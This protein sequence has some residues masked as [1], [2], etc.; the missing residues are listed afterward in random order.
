MVDSDP[1]R[2][3]EKR[4]RIEWS[5]CHCTAH[6]Q[7]SWASQ[8]SQSKMSLEWASE[9]LHPIAPV[10]LFSPDPGHASHSFP[11]GPYRPPFFQSMVLPL[12]LCPQ[13]L[14]TG[15]F[16]CLELCS[17]LFSL[18][19]IFS[20]TNLDLISEVLCFGKPS[21]TSLTRSNAPCYH[22]C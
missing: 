18:L 5:H 13:G 19:C 8:G 20:N 17:S 10:S 16:W 22:F 1:R 21:L 3:S 15:Y 7:P 11:S 4:L 12:V 2:K 6:Q 9:A 14:C